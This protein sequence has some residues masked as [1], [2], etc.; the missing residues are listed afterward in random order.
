MSTRRKFIKNAALLGSAFALAR[1]LAACSGGKKT[2]QPVKEIGLQLFSIREALDKDVKGSLAKVAAIGYDHVETFFDYNKKS[3]KAAFWGLQVPELK[4]L[5]TD[6]DLKSYSGHYQLHDFLTRG[7]GDQSALSY[8]IDIAAG[9]GQQYFIVPVPPLMLLDQLGA[10]DFQF[11]AS[12]LNKAGELCRKAGL[13]IGYH[14][15]F[16]EFRNLAGGK[17]GL[18]ILIAGTEP[19]LVTFEMDLFWAKKSGINPDD[20]FSRY[21]GRFAMWHVKDMDKNN[22]AP[23]TGGDQDKKPSLDILQTISYT[24]VGTGAIDFREIFSH[25]EQSGLRHIYVEQDVIKQDVFASVKQSF[26]YVKK[27]LIS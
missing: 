23:I 9:L 24:E 18:D 12:Q 25:Q 20:Y 27:N 19:D 17:K 26:S 15:H 22:T 2:F 4:K 7:N 21:P 16:W 8:Q 1:P 11:M 13:T 14:N 6:S 10:D 5:L 3:P